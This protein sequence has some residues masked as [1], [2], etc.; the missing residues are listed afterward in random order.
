MN[1]ISHF[2][3]IL[4]LV[5][6]SSAYP[7]YR[8]RIPNGRN[9]RD[10]QG[11]EWPGVGHLRSGGGGAR[12]PF[13]KDFKA[14]GFQWTKEL[15]EKDSDGD[16]LS[17]GQEL[18]DPNCNWQQGQTP[19]FDAG[20]T[21][22]GFKDEERGGNV[23]SC[24]KWSTNDLPTPVKTRNLTFP[25]HPVSTERTT[26]VKYA[27]TFDN[28]QD[29]YSVKFAPII[30]NLEVVHHMILY[31]CNSASQVA[32]FQ[33]APTDEGGMPCEDIIFA[34]A[35]GGKAFCAP[36]NV[37]FA[38]FKD[39]PY[40]VLEIH[41]D[42]PKGLVGLTDSSGFEVT[43]F[44]QSSAT[45]SFNRAGF[46]WVGAALRKLSVPPNEKNYHVTAPCRYPSLPKTGVTAFAY[47]L[48][49]HLLGRKLWT[50]LVRAG[51]SY[52]VGCNTDYD[53]DIQEIVPLQSTVTIYP[54]DTL[55]AHCVYDSS[56]RST[57]TTGGDAT[58]QEMCINFILYYPATDTPQKCLTKDIT[59]KKDD[60]TVTTKT[61]MAINS[62]VIP[63]TVGQ[64]KLPKWLVIHIAC[65]SLAWGLILP[66][67]ILF[68]LLFKERLPKSWFKVHISLQLT[69]FALVVVGGLYALTRNGGGKFNHTHK[70]IGLIILVFTVLQ[71]LNGI[72]RPH[73]PSSGETKKSNRRAWELIHKFIGYSIALLAFVNLYLGTQLVKSV[74][75][76]RLPLSWFIGIGLSAGVL[77]FVVVFLSVLK[78]VLLEL[79]TIRFAV[80]IVTH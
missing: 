36:K 44:P 22:P 19:Q 17:N 25:P 55:K 32:P 50:E 10:N 42:N 34:W 20:I 38:H 37:G 31:R 29:Y 47:I 76:Q 79:L 3:I 40:M 1:V 23:D 77:V 52:D 48:H 33:N 57:K 65:M 28:D 15:C 73:K 21:H 59:M 61:C 7:E 14:A 24:S 53:F 8:D 35:V 12:N 6:L 70:V 30:D 63:G 39:T 4:N 11:N 75:A 45:A 26:Y 64:A 78:T 66:F 43:Y 80:S 60:N 16:G 27:F 54:S 68:P 5:I 71:P 67:G 58:D 72:F 18:G 62:T 9:V 46:M 74:F 49:A 56:S 51:Q 2:I 13:G 69:G 41:Y